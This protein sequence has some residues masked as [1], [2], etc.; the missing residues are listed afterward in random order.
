MLIINP[1]PVIHYR[2]LKMNL[3]RYASTRQRVQELV[4]LLNRRS[5]LAKTE[6]SRTIFSISHKILH[7]TIA[8]PAHMVWFSAA[9]LWEI[10]IDSCVIVLT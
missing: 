6:V 10:A 4:Y 9:S 1:L 5:A 2:L 7:L 3:H 8:N